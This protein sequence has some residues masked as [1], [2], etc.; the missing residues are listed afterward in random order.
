LLPS[1]PHYFVHLEA[2]KPFDIAWQIDTGLN[3]ARMVGGV[4]LGNAAASPSP[5]ATDAAIG[6]VL[7][8]NNKV[9]FAIVKTGMACCKNMASVL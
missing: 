4:L 9:R 7:G 3:A 2:G 1:V 6:A 5:L 8:I